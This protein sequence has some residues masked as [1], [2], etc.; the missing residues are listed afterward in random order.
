M[1]YDAYCEWYLALRH[2]DYTYMT[3]RRRLTIGEV[4]QRHIPKVKWVMLEK[5]AHMGMVTADQWP[6]IDIDGLKDV[7]VDT[8]YDVLAQHW[9][10]TLTYRTPT[11]EWEARFIITSREID[12]ASHRL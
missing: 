6:S 11:N 3:L 2:Q 9:K 12:S 10:C 4:L 8:Q 5:A 1:W 7:H